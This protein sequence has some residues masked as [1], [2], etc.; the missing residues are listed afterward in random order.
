MR[1]AASYNFFNGEEHLLQ[2]MRMLRGC[3]DHLSIVWQEV[4]NAGAAISDMGRRV[5]QDAVHKHLVDEVIPFVP[6]LDRSRKTNETIKRQIGL[7]AARRAGATHFLTLDADEFYR[8]PEVEAAK[9]AIQKS[10]WRSTSVESFLHIKRPIWRAYDVTCCCFITE[11]GPATQMGAAGFPCDHVDPSRRMTADPDSHHHFR[12]D[13]V[14][15][16]HMNLVRAD[17]DSKFTNTST[18]DKGFLAKVR[19]EWEKW[20]PGTPF[21]FPNKGTL[22]LEQVDNEFAAFDPETMN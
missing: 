2:S 22:H 13:T 16:Y 15:M 4:S 8:P 21:H 5:V 10:G 9:A 14:A 17:I 19:A 12:P 20:Q 11:I 1:L 7:D 3:V 18:L 6:D